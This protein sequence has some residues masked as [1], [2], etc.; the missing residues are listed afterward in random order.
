MFWPLTA[1]SK[2]DIMKVNS[3]HMVY[4]LFIAQINKLLLHQMAIA[5][6]TMK[7]IK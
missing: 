1:S 6:Q 3:L 7:S 2:A 4:G 5:D